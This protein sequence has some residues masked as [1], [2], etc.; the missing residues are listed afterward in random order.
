MIA[1]RKIFN[2]KKEANKIEE[3]LA[4]CK[5]DD[6]PDLFNIKYAINKLNEMDGVGLLHL[7]T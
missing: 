4:V 1:S 2:I 7:K 3:E 5:T 6:G